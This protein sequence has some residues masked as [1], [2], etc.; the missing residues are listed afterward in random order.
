VDVR[1]DKSV[2]GGLLIWLS[3]ADP[4]TLEKCPEERG[5]F[6]G[7]GGVVLTTALVAAASCVFALTVGF[8]APL[9]VAL[10]AGLLWGLATMNLDR[11]LVSATPGR[12]RWYQN[13]ASVFPRL[14]LAL[15]IGAVISTPLVLWMFQREV[16]AQ[17]E[18]ARLDRAAA[19]QQQLD[20]EPRYRDIPALTAEVAQLQSVVDGTTIPPGAEGPEIAG[21]R[22][23]YESLERQYQQAQSLV[24][25]DLRQQRDAIKASLDAAIANAGRTY[26]DSLLKARAAAADRLAVSQAMLDGRRA[27]REAA[28]ATFAADNPQH[29]GL[30]AQLDALRQLTGAN[31]TLKTVYITILLVIAA[32]GVLPV[33]VKFLMSLGPPSLYDQIHAHSKQTRLAAAAAAFEFE[34]SLAKTEYDRRLAEL[35]VTTHRIGRWRERELKAA[36]ELVGRA[37]DSFDA[38][39]ASK[40]RRAP[41]PDG[42]A[43]W[44]DE[45]VPPTGVASEETGEVTSGHRWTYDR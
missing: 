11:W 33:L 18:A 31:G 17:L 20:Q 37:D 41:D 12:A 7:V 45:E 43:P 10:P 29:Q 42:F 44:P 24:A 21:L 5:K 13:L 28:E 6:R 9:L 36:A 8:S 2:K 3:G 14:L 38:W 23:E 34:Q 35:D 19:F 1:V 4:R 26:Q 15:V 22:A 32:I 40:K 30:L 39:S 25:E 16:T 27:D